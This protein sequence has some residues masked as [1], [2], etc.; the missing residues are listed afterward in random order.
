VSGSG[1]RVAVLVDAV[2]GLAV[3]LLSLVLHLAQMVR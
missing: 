3:L 2:R 1:D